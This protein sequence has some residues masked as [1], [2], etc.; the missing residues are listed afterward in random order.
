MTILSFL[1]ITPISWTR[2]RDPVS[3]HSPR[4]RAVSPVAVQPPAAS[5]RSAEQLHTEEAH[6]L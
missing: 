5:R 1:K 2:A 6:S 3:P 4:E